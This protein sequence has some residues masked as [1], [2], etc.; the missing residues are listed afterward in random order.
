VVYPGGHEWTADVSAA[1][2]RFLSRYIS[3]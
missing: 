1:A 2:S 3:D